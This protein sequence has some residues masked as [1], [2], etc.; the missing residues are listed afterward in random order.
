MT[1]TPGVRADHDEKSTAELVHD[2]TD[3]V[4]RLARTEVT[5]AVRG[6]DGTQAAQAERA[7]AVTRGREREG[8]RP[9]R[10]GGR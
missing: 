6:A 7:D 9:R 4:N 10:Q 3:Q 1:V 2:L 5:L 8:R